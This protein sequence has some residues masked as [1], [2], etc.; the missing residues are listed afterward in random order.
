MKLINGKLGL[1]RLAL[2]SVLAL[3]ASMSACSEEDTGVA[4]NANVG[5]GDGDAGS[6]AGSEWFVVST[7]IYGDTTTSYIPV[8]SS[9]DVEEISLKNAKELD[10]RGTIAQVG[11]W[12]FVATSTAP[13]VTRYTIGDDGSL[14]EDGRLNF[15][16]H[17]VPEFFAINA[18]GAVFVNE[19]KAYIFNGSDGSHVIWNPTTMKI[20]GEIEGPGIV[21]EG[22]DMESVAVVRGNRM[23][24]IFTFLNYETWE[25][26]QEPQYLAVYDVETDELLSMSEET[27]C[28]QLYALPAVDENDDIYFSGHVWTPGLALTS[29]YPKSCS[30]RVKAGEDELDADWQLDFADITDGREAATM[31]YLGDG[32]A[33]LDVF[34]DERV[35]ITDDS[36][37][38]ELVST[39]DWRLW[40]I[41][42]E[43]KTGE[44][45]EGIGFK[46]AGLTDIKVGDRTFL[47]L[48]NADWSE[49]TAWELVDGEAVEGF[50]IQGN[51]YQTLQLR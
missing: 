20:T 7:Q 5:D 51:S 41:D 8:V 38:E 21:E 29:D 36:D 49:T 11:E 46:G 47:M 22:Y 31:R 14:T 27:R 15:S 26:L 13:V 43:A 17:G 42:L 18:W 23:Y 45:V 4:D 44:P 32:K 25:F 3:A 39:S 6:D 33:L 12:L 40:L 48:P 10:G 30:L 24:R 2:A 37:P 1:D 28:A 35:E 16:N 50:K 9:L 19:E 34:H